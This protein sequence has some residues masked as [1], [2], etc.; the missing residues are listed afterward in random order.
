MKVVDDL[1]MDAGLYPELLKLIDQYDADTHMD[2][3]MKET[4]QD[5]SSSHFD[6]CTNPLSPCRVK[7][8]KTACTTTVRNKCLPLSSPRIRSA[9]LF[10]SMVNLVLRNGQHAST[11]IIFTTSHQQFQTTDSTQNRKLSRLCVLQMSVCLANF[12]TNT[13]ALFFMRIEGLLLDLNVF[14]CNE[15]ELT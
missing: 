6:Y 8:V 3:T 13:S 9:I 4:S 5:A 14:I 15:L 12:R 2:A 10:G 7:C 11:L 1:L